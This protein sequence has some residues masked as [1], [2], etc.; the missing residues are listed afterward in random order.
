MGLGLTSFRRAT[1]IVSGGGARTH[2]PKG[3]CGQTSPQYLG[4][5]AL[6]Q[7]TLPIRLPP[8][9]AYTPRGGAYGPCPTP[10]SDDPREFGMTNVTRAHR[11]S[12]RVGLHGGRRKAHNRSAIPGPAIRPALHGEVSRLPTRSVRAT[13]LLR[14]WQVH[15]RRTRPGA[16]E[17]PT[18]SWLSR[19]AVRPILLPFGRIRPAATSFVK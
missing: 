19:C 14:R 13:R 1:R 15:R 18:G 9:A 8:S 7:I 10:G 2:R 12:P 4:S 3:R 17:T 11:T 5:V 6:S 16:P